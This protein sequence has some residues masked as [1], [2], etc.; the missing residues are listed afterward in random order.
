M[1]VPFRVMPEQVG[2]A[3]HSLRVLN[4]AGANVTIPYKERVIP[5]LDVLSEGANI[6]GAVN[7]IV[8]KDGTLKGYNTNAIGVMDA[9]G[10]I[11][12]DIAGKTALVFGTGGIARA[13]VFILK[14]L[15]A[16]S[17]FIIG[18]NED[19]AMRLSEKVGGEVMAMDSDW[20]RSI[21][22]HL[23]VN[24]TSVS[25]PDESPE[26]A[27][28]AKVLNIPQCELIFDLNYGR[29]ENFWEVA[30]LS[31]NVRFLDGSTTLAF[32]ARRTFMLWTGLDVSS[33]EFLDCL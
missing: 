27:D 25:S 3:M 8:C 10:E 26:L 32:Q 15:R 12:F 9:L 30:A 16:E 5:Y 6:I 20:T 18:R 2:A 1:Y 24:A 11:G 31:R 17:V 23:V 21:P 29:Q 28:I 19:A 14:W 22:A 13:I 4:I 7:T 33:K